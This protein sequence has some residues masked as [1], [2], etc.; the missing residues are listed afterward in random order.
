M[1]NDFFTVFCGL[2]T[3]SVLCRYF[4]EQILAMPRSRS[5]KIAP[6][7]NLEIIIT[8]RCQPNPPSQQSSRSALRTLARSNRIIGQQAWLQRNPLGKHERSSQLE[9]GRSSFQKTK[10]GQTLMSR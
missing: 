2:S 10:N 4:R 9:R 5:P 7:S 3:E 1:W 6:C 8:R